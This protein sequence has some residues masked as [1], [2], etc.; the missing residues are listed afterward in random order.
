MPKDDYKQPDL[1]ADKKRE[2][3]IKKRQNQIWK[4]ISEVEVEL[5]E[6]CEAIVIA[7]FDSETLK[8]KLVATT[9]ARKKLYEEL[10]NVESQ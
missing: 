9:L 5:V 4:E 7:E 2:S 1:S 3:A 6:I 8:H 10:E